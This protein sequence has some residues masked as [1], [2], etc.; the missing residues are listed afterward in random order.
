M[1]GKVI[2]S[3]D[4]ILSLCCA[5]KL[6][7]VERCCE[8]P[9]QSLR[10]RAV[11]EPSDVR[12]CVEPC[13][14]HGGADLQHFS[15][16][17]GSPG[18]GSSYPAVVPCASPAGNAG[19]H[20]AS[21]IH[22]VR[23]K[24][25]LPHS[26]ATVSIPVHSDQR[27]LHEH[28]RD[29]Q[30]FHARSG[31]RRSRSHPREFGP[32]LARGSSRSGLLRCAGVV[33]S[34][35][36]IERSLWPQSGLADWQRD[37]LR[38]LHSGIG[39]HPFR[40]ATTPSTSETAVG[41]TTAATCANLSGAQIGGSGSNSST[42]PA[43]QPTLLAQIASATGWNLSDIQTFASGFSL[44]ILDFRNEIRLVQLATCTSIC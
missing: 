8:P 39:C 43:N 30:S 17:F 7:V 36:K 5:C 15:L 34:M 37:N 44:S 31:F 32:I 23:R 35:A 22:A 26:L 1:D 12:G 29:R 20:A 9:D 2:G 13:E 11:G 42:A 19:T 38:H 25:K 3:E 27:L 14:P 21:G 24:W 10:W 18:F 4:R 28:E 16:H 6:F 33:Q 40:P 41:P